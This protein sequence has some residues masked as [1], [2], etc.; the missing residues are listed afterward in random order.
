MKHFELAARGYHARLDKLKV[1]RAARNDVVEFDLVNGLWFNI[2][3][4]I[5]FSNLF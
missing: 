5:L 3:V 4:F 1:N 2:H